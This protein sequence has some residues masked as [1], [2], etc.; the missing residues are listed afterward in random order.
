[1][2]PKAKT[3]LLV[4]TLPGETLVYDLERHRAHCLNPQAAFLLQEANGSRTL[5]ELAGLLSRHFSADASLEAVRIGLL[6]LK[7][8]RLLEWEEDPPAPGRKNPAHGSRR[9]AIRKMAT[10]GVALPAVMTVVSPLTAQAT[11]LIPARCDSAV[12]I[13]KCCRNRK[14][15][16]MV[17]GRYRCAGERC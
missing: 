7:R 2:H 15:C 5:E 13:G 12:D 3:D 10:L 14:L 17:G 11:G 9:D 8:A 16:I 1:M 6:R 4:E